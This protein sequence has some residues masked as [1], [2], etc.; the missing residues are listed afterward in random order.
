MVSLG[1][2]CTGLD[3]VAVAAEKI[4]LRAVVEFAS[5]VDPQ[6]RKL[7]LRQRHRPRVLYHDMMLRSPEAV[8]AV[9]IYTCGFP[10][11]PV[12]TQGL[13]RGAKDPRSKVLPSAFR[14]IAAQRPAVVVMENVK[15]LLAKTHRRFFKRICSR[16]S[17]ETSQLM[18]AMAHYSLA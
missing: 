10:C 4:G 9:Q 11:Q 5:E 15:G 14:Y 16:R 7:L 13:N 17:I 2:D 18:Y 12:S 6:T 3:T 1:S 8:P